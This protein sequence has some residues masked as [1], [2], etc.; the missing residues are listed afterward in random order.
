MYASFLKSKAHGRVLD[1]KTWGKFLAYF[2]AMANGL[3][4]LGNVLYEDP[5]KFSWCL[6]LLFSTGDLEQLCRVWGL[7]DYNGVHEMCCACLAN[8]TTLPFTDNQEDSAWRDT[9]PLPNEVVGSVG[10]LCFGLEMLS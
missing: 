2:D 3:D 5:A 7:Q 1:D 10:V 9:C 6:L 8:R 4:E